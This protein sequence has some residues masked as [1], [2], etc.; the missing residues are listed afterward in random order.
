MTVTERGIRT[1]ELKTDPIHFEAITDGRK[2]FELRKDDRPGGFMAGDRLHLREF[3]R[4]GTKGY[5]GRES[6]E[7]VAYVLRYHEGLASGYV[8]L[9]LEPAACTSC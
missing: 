8:I 3:D 1:H 7:S 9:G 6:W 2:R 5:T 4:V